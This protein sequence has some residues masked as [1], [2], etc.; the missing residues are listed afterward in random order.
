M[1]G[2]AEFF[3]NGSAKDVRLNTLVISHPNFTK[4]Y[5]LVSNAVGGITATI[6]DGTEVEFQEYPFLLSEVGLRDTL[7]FGFT[8]QLGDLG[9]I[10][11]QEVDAVM[12]ANGMH[13]HPT[14]IF[15][16]YSSGDLSTPLEGPFSLRMVGP[17]IGSQGTVFRAEPIS[18]NASATGD[19]YSLERFPG[20][21][22]VI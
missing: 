21:V 4:T 9:E 3:F 1:P 17:S 18:A 10:V 14:V 13:I 6:E 15:R 2:Y 11:P 22:G 8:V 16:A 7:D 12:A 19:V 5:S 20:L